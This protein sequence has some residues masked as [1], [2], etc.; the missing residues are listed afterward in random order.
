M[1]LRLTLISILSAVMILSGLGMTWVFRHQLTAAAAAATAQALKRTWS[2]C[3]W[4]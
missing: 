3:C 4:P 2:A 1:G